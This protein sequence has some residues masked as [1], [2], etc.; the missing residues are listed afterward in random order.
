MLVINEILGKFQENR[1]KVKQFDIN[2]DNEK[3]LES[4]S[5]RI[6]VKLENTGR[7]LGKTLKNVVNTSH[8]F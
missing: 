1:E 5:E 3:M 2:V 8:E 6:L 7:H 4:F